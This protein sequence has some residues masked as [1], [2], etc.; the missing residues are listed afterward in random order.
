[1]QLRRRYANL[2][3]PGDFFEM[4]TM[5]LS[6]IALDHPVRMHSP[7]AFHV[8]DKIIDR[9]TTLES[10]VLDPPDLRSFLSACATPNYMVRAARSPSGKK[11][12]KLWPRHRRRNG[13]RFCRT[14]GNL[15]IPLASSINARPIRRIDPPRNFLAGPAWPL[16]DVR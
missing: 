14:S 13:I 6:S 12:E 9:P 7:V 15:K 3:I 5:W 2:Y 11:A 4:R 16:S 1:M 8:L 10:A